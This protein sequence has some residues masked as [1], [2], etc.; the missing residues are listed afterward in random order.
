MLHGF[1]IVF[2]LPLLLFPFTWSRDLYEEGVRYTK[3]SFATLM[4]LMSQW[5]AP[6][7]LSIT[8]EKEGLGRFSDEQIEQTIV[9]NTDGKVVALKLPTK[10]ILIAN[11]QMY[12][13]WWYAWCLT[14]FM[15]TA[16]DVFIVLK[17]SLKWMPIIGWAMQIF[18]FIFLARSWASDRIQLASHLSALGQQA[19]RKDQPLTLLLYPEG[20]LVSKDT[21]PISKKFADKI[22]VPDMANTLLPRS[23]GLHYSLRSL[24]PRVPTL[25]L[26]DITIVYPGIPPMEYGQSYYTL[27]SIFFDGIPPPVIHMH[28]RVFDVSRDVPIGDVSASYP[29]VFPKGQANGHTVEVDFPENEK[30]KFDLWL[31]QLW[32]DKDEFITR[33]HQTPYEMASVE[34]PLELRHKREIPD[35][36]GFFL[37][38]LVRSV[39]AKLRRT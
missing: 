28:L 21:R 18:K 25:Q 17:R 39:S 14:Y 32:R 20:T 10:S 4:I 13:D 19:E 26:I 31:R 35:A 36:F 8:F 38:A 37:P 34:I 5:F 11:H 15:G 16:K 7:R 24:A 22:G 2:L 30:I 6:T 1:Q 3:G 23:T 29:N 9:R 33:F 12:A 27:R